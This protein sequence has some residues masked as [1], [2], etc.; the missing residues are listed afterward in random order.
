MNKIIRAWWE[1]E[2]EPLRTRMEAALQELDEVTREL[3]ASGNERQDR[4][5]TQKIAET[6]DALLEL[7]NNSF[8]NGAEQLIL[9]L[10]AELGTDQKGRERE[11]VTNAITRLVEKML[12]NDGANIE[13][14][15]VALAMSDEG[16]PATGAAAVASQPEVVSPEDMPW[17][18]SNECTSC[19]D[20]ITIN[21]SIFAYDENELAII[22]NPHGGPFR[23]IVKAAEKCPSG[24][25][26]PGKPL[27]PKEKDLDKWTRRAAKYQ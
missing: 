21:R 25:I 2:I 3:E 22:K 18:E 12:E 26:H 17:I 20:C 19:D 9:P 13:A 11:A 5:M 15:G 23:D 14:L 7:R 8:F 24:I 6:R 10:E 1:S 27:D 4:E 16:P